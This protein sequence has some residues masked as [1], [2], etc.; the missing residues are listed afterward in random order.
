MNDTDGR[1]DLIDGVLQKNGM[2]TV[3]ISEGD[4][5]TNMRAADACPVGIIR[6]G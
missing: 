6:V 4:H 2:V 1:S 5:E 3:Q